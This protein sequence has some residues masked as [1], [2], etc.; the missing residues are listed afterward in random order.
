MSNF[1]SIDKYET[2]TETNLAEIQGGDLGVLVGIF[3]AAYVIG[4]DLARRKK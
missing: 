1:N 3:A 4:S 2:L